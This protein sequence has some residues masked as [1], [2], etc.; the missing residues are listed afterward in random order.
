MFMPFSAPA[1]VH[2]INGCG[3]HQHRSTE[4]ETAGATTLMFAPL[5][6]R[7]FTFPAAMCSPHGLVSHGLPSRRAAIGP[8][9]E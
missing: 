4:V 6:N 9:V 3:D 5:S 2:E 1:R 7:S 8:A